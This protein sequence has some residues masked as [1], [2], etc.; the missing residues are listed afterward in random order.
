MHSVAAMRGKI[1]AKN[2]KKPAN[3]E[4]YQKAGARDGA[5]SIPQV[6]AT[7]SDGRCAP[8][9]LTSFFEL[10]HSIFNS[11]D[12]GFINLAF[13]FGF[14]PAGILTGRQGGDL[15]LPQLPTILK[16]SP[17]QT[18]CFDKTL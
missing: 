3:I 11:Y 6:N 18:R 13:F 10:L 14:S 9:C 2:A 5:L 1:Y 17:Q 15:S 7:S 4:Q 8:Y 16:V 12:A